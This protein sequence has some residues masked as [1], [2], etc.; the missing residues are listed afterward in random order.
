MNA[1]DYLYVVSGTDATAAEVVTLD[2]QIANQ[3]PL[4]V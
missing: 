2:Y 4:T 1:G 3:A